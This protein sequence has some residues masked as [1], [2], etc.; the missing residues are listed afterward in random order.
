MSGGKTARGYDEVHGGF[1]FGVRN[2]GGT[3]LLEFAKAFD[4]VLA[5]T[6]FQKREDH[7]VTFRSRV[8]KTQIDY[9]LLR[10]GDKGLCTDCK[11]IPSECLS[12]Q[13]RLLVMDLEVKGVRKKRAGYS[14]GRKG[15]WWWNEEVQE[16]VEAKKAAYL[17]LVGSTN[18][19]ERRSYRECYKKARRE[20]KL[21][22]TAAK[23]ASFERLYEDLGGKRGDRKL[24]K[25][26]KIRERK[27]RDLDRVRCIKDEDGKVLVEEA[28][29]RHRWREYFHRLLNEEGDR[30]IMLGEL[31]NSESR[32]DFG[33]C[34]RIRCEEV[35]VA[36]R[37]MSR[38][39]ATGPDEI[40]MEF[41]KE[42]G[43]IQNCN[44]Y[45][46]IKLLSHTMKVWER[47]VEKRV[48]TCVSISE[49]QFGFMPGRSTTE[50]IHLVRR[51]VEQYRERK[52]DL[53]MVFIDLEK[54]YDKVPREVLWRCLEPIIKTRGGV[55]IRLE[56]WRQ[57]LESK[58]FKLSRSKTEYLECKFSEERHEE[59][60]EVKIDTQVIPTRES[61]KY[62][63]SIIQGNGEIDEDVTHRIGAGWMRGRLAS[64]IL[65]DKNVPPRLKGKFYKV[66]VRPAMLKDKIRNEVNR[67]KVGVA[68]VE[69]KLREARLQ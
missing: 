5:N 62:L 61:F 11:V 9:L 32:R 27:A 16:K 55:N 31:E 4:L 63:G 20:A 69:A 19:E 59:E 13:H 17:K 48:R 56:V 65:C 38:G 67:D 1:G 2:E 66:V 8:A 40:P 64:G 21:A 42:A 45:R 35:V 12:M 26:A 22:V 47:V 51:L 6:G 24:Y 3:S 14:G 44:N 46:G 53:H 37:K 68:S 29:I 15:D 57:A 28:C 7:L 34:R 41:L 23:T 49:N 10:R 25:L 18:E 39:K 54:A 58:G 30:N 33:F 36:I 43:D 50:A 60:V 52:K